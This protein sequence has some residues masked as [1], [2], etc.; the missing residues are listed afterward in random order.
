MSSL[1]RSGLEAA[2]LRWHEPDLT[3]FLDGGSVGL[4]R[5]LNE[6]LL[7]LLGDGSE[8]RH[9][10]SALGAIV[11]EDLDQ[12]AVTHPSNAARH[13]ALQL[14]LV[15]LIRGKDVL[16]PCNGRMMTVDTRR[17][18][19]IATLQGP[20]LAQAIE[21]RHGWAAAG[22]G[23]KVDARADNQPYDR[24]GAADL[25]ECGF[26]PALV[27]AFERRA[28]LHH[29]DAD[30]LA[31]V[32]RVQ[33]SLLAPLR[34][35]FSLAGVLIEIGDEALEE[36]ARRAVAARTG[37]RGLLELLGGVL[38]PVL[39]EVGE[40]EEGVQ[41]V[42]LRALGSVEFVHGPSLCQVL[43]DDPVPPEDDLPAPLRDRFLRELLRRP[44]R[45]DAAYGEA[46]LARE[47]ELSSW[48]E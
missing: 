36:A 47:E 43:A 11:L 4:A 30:D 39:A 14:G 46:R 25:I 31:A 45:S 10:R 21:K 27:A 42:V 5:S 1:V 6:M 16:L 23:A 37:A 20:G 24:F 28:G 9:P 7:P 19:F 34:S 3:E 40:R 41:K 8:R 48:I 22:F 29:L 12:F 35:I 38:E 2:G 32:C 17:V 18:L 13:E 44:P 26:H 33:P 15:R